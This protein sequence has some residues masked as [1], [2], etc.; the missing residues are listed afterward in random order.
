[1]VTTPATRIITHEFDANDVN[2]LVLM[3]DVQEF[4]HN[5]HT[6]ETKRVALGML[7]TKVWLDGQNIEITGVIPVEN[8]VIVT[9]HSWSH[10]YN[11][12]QI[13]PFSI[14]V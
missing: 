7:G 5:V 8:D 4:R 6:A 10:G 3:F 12:T 2:Y 1:M 14:T 9:T 13:L 11:K